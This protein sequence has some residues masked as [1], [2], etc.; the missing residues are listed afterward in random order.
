MSKKVKAPS[1][2]SEEE[3]G[4]F[5]ELTK[6]ERGHIQFMREDKARKYLFSKLNER[7]IPSGYDIKNE[8]KEISDNKIDDSFLSK[9]V[10]EADLQEKEF[11]CK[12]CGQGFNSDEA[13]V[14]HQKLC[15]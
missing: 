11:K 7:R 1:Y 12:F 6:E 3:K 10:N 14:K 15:M 9:K 4:L 13:R 5:K 8:I 2:F